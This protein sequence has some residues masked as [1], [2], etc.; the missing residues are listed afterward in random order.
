MKRIVVITCTVILGLIGFIWFVNGFKTEFRDNVDYLAD[1]KWRMV[2]NAPFVDYYFQHFSAPLAFQEVEDHRITSLQGNNLE[3]EFKD[4]FSKDKDQLYYVPL[5]DSAYFTAI[6]FAVISTGIDGILNF[7]NGSPMTIS[8]FSN[9]DGFYNKLTQEPGVYQGDFIDTVFKLKDRLFGEKD[10]L[11]EFINCKEFY[12]NSYRFE[13]SISQ[14][15][16][17]AYLGDYKR[18]IGYYHSITLNDSIPYQI[19]N[20]SL[21]AYVAEYRVIFEFPSGQSMFG[22]NSSIGIV[23]QL[24]SVNQRNRLIV[25]NNCLAKYP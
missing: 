17:S 16:N 2:Y 13:Q 4:P 22:W 15:V 1:R 5:F 12:L 24:M 8:E 25:M 19:H 10:L 11:I 9:L 23:G 3:C 20:D 7:E 6:G 21:F 18:Q 14:L